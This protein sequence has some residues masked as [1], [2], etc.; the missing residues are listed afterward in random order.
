YKMIKTNIHCF[1]LLFSYLIQI[2]LI[3]GQL[4]QKNIPDFFYNVDFSGPL[5]DQAVYTILSN[6]PVSTPINT[7]VFKFTVKP[8]TDDNQP[9]FTPRKYSNSMRT[10]ASGSITVISNHP[11]FT[12]INLVNDSYA[13]VS[14][15]SPL[16]YF[17]PFN[18]Y[19]F[20]IIARQTIPTRPP[21]TS[22]A[23][24]QINLENDNVHDPMFI[25]ENQIFYISETAPVGI[26]FGTVYATDRDNDDITYTI[27]CVQFCIESST[28]VL[29]LEQ[30]LDSSSQS[31]YSLSVTAT[32]SGS[33]C[34][35]RPSCYKRTKSIDIRI[36]VTV[37][38]TKSP[39]FLN[40]IC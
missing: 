26:Q 5:F 6:F 30:P 12:V 28:G 1:H 8:R 35:L 22:I 32:D 24:V 29:R 36:I 18:R 38:N 11:S 40:E 25:P 15:I 37:V 2:N 13:L 17:S 7:E 4:V 16:N 33:S 31:E 3:Y 23:Q 9:S 10:I 21:V 39:R 19:L 14:N 34:L 27:D 20:Q